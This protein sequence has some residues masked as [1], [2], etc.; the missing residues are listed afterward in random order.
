MQASLETS[1][2]PPWMP[3]LAV[4]CV[5]TVVFLIPRDLFF[6]ETRDVE[7]WFGFELRGTAALL[8]APLHWGIFLLGELNPSELHGS[9]GFVFSGVGG[10]V[11]D[12]GT[13]V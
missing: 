12:S 6:P 9:G 1:Q 4:F 10:A 8:T 11:R 2:R 7:V 13:L 5:A 3:A